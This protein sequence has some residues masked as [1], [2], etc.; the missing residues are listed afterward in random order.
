[1]MAQP[2]ILTFNFHEPYLVLMAKT[3]LTIHAGMYDEGPLRRDWVE[4]FRP[5]P[6]NIVLV[7][8][9]EWRSEL[10]AGQYDVVIAQNENNALDIFRA[11]CPKLLLCHNRRR[12]LAETVRIHDSDNPQDAYT[13]L[14][15]K[16]QVFFEFIFIS[17]SKRADYGIPG[18]VILPGIDPDDYGGWTGEERIVLRVG[19]CMRERNLMF[20]VDFQERVVADLPNRVLGANPLIPD[21]RPADS[22]D[23][24]KTAYRTARC[25]LHVSR[26]EYEDGYNLVTLEALATGTPVV[27]LANATSPITD[28]VDGFLSS[29][30]GELNARCRQLLDDLDRARTIGEHGREM[31]AR[32]FPI[33]AFTEQWREAIFTAAEKSIRH[34]PRNHTTTGA[35]TETEAGPAGEPEG[36][37]LL[38]YAASPMTTGRYF[39]RALRKRFHIITAGLRVPEDVYPLWGFDSQ[40][41]PYP[42][43]DIDLPL[44]ADFNTLLQGVPK[45][46]DPDFYLWIDS[47]PKTVLPGTAGYPKLKACYLIDTHIAPDLRLE[48]ARHFNITFLAQKAQVKP[49]QQAGIK[50]ALWIPLACCPELHDLPEMPRT[51]D[52]AYVG[53]FSTEED[54]RRQQLLNTVAA[55]YPNHYIGRAWPHEMARIYAQA[56]IV[57]NTCVN[58]DVNMRVF[59]A[60]AAGALLITDPAVGLTDL[61][62]DREHLV[63]YQSSSELF[64]LIDYYLTHEDERHRIAMQGQEE[65]LAAHTYDH[66][67]ESMIRHIH[68]RFGPVASKP[69]IAYDAANYYECARPE[70]LPFVPRNARRLLDVGCASGHFGCM[71]KSHTNIEEVVGVELVEHAYEKSRRVLDRVFLGDLETMDL[72]Y[73][74]DYFDCITC[75]DVLEHMIEPGAVLKKLRRMLSPEGILIISIPN[76]RYHAIFS[77]ITSGRFSYM[78]RGI[79][80]RTHLRFYT[81]E[82]LRDMLTQAGFDVIKLAPL[83]CAT[84]DQAP[85]DADGNLRFG[86][87]F[88]DQPDAQTYEDLRT[89]QHVALAANPN[90]DRLAGARAALEEGDVSTAIDLA[91]NACAVDEAERRRILAK[92][93]ARLG[94]V[95]R[96]I[97]HFE[98]ARQHKP[99]DLELA[100]EYGMALIA[101]NRIAQA[102]P[103]LE[104]ALAAHPGNAR[105]TGA[106][107]LIDL[108]NGNHD[109]AYTRLRAA[110]NASFEHRTL[111]APFISAAEAA[112]RATDAEDL[113][114]AFAEFYPGDITLACSY[115]RLLALL[116]RR[117][118]ARERLALALTLDPENEEAQ[119]LLAE[120][121][122]VQQ[123]QPEST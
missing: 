84:E 122:A 46:F 70:L 104:Q 77:T 22:F 39:E 117:G 92:A 6:D 36:N 113:V 105:F 69:E 73:P 82:T 33:A 83:S 5:R 96:V 108:S 56:K 115:A 102:Q 1:M 106:L 72:P 13:Y 2:R 44:E 71:V 19:N 90:V 94:Q 41:P 67:V 110:L 25:L 48:M 75:A 29:D 31:V 66:R 57:V 116:G 62:R 81:R 34:I 61:F 121:D 114:H 58:E 97:T 26:E 80:D 52:I 87:V 111:V 93:C 59:E 76:V 91:E 10:M 109:S 16:L 23:A 8:E 99:D 103:L 68:T 54:S 27:S 53:S 63:I 86:H 107:G 7:P 4:A 14:L 17:E 43:H 78:D 65:V 55:R 28:G 95:D 64:D 3:G 101:I 74:D 47:G 38:H 32:K 89:Y 15:E 11:P 40:P 112:G 118:D 9:R 42:P 51:Y 85:R 50:H 45:D 123:D 88:F 79:L 30:A 35:T 120:I 100:G 60:L 12:F 20:D 18:R 119:T 24:L 21:S 49:F 98:A 37:L